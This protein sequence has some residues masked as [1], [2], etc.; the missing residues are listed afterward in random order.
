M[1]AVGSYDHLLLYITQKTRDSNFFS[2][3]LFFLVDLY[4]L[5]SIYSTCDATN[6]REI[7]HFIY[8][9]SIYSLMISIIY[10]R[11]SFKLKSNFHLSL[12]LSTRQKCEAQ[13]FSLH[14]THYFAERAADPDH[15]N[16]AERAAIYSQRVK[17]D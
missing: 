11:R 7:R 13:V 10:T 14:S 16:K 3:G 6:E 9:Q 15:R 17:P 1:A 2:L 4:A 12:F 8:T 5:A